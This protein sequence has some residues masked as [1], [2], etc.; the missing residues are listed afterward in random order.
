MLKVLQT[1]HFDASADGEKRDNLLSKQ[2]G[3]QI[4]LG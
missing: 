2:K 1:I 3:N 4:C